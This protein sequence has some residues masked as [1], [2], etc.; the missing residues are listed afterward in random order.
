MTVDKKF[1]LTPVNS[2]KI[3]GL[4][5]RTE[6]T[7]GGISGTYI[8]LINYSQ[9]IIKCPSLNFEDCVQ[10]NINQSKEMGGS[11]I[12]FMI[13]KQD[14]QPFQMITY[15]N[16]DANNN[17]NYNI[18]NQALSSLNLQ[19]FNENNEFI[20]D[21]SDYLLTLKFT[22]FDRFE[23]IFKELGLQSLSL[24]DDI[25]FTLLNILFKRKNNLLL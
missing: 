9:I 25:H 12:L 7:T 20:T 16:E 22:L 14:I 23:P 4:N 5:Q 10:D 6:I 13:D 2:Q 11:S 15:K 17:Y 1:Y 3:L 18:R 19:L 21:A 24:L 8:N